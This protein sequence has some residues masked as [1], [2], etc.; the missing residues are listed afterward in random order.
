AGRPDPRLGGE[1]EVRLD[2][3]GIRD[4]G[5]KRGE[6]RERVEA[7]D[8]CVRLPSGDP[9]LE[10]RSGRR[11]KE[12]RKPDARRESCENA[13]DRRGRV[14]RA[15][16]RPRKDRRSPRSARSGE[17]RERN[18]DERNVNGALGPHIEP[19]R[20]AIGIKVAREENRLK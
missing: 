7:K 16:G 9:R 18:G 3:E 14:G 13:R 20:E 12:K 8:P 1:R 5:E 19:P 11:E 2:D 6:V 17:R 15:E 10:K 4:E